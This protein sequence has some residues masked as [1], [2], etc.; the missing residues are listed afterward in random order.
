[1]STATIVLKDI[2]APA[3]VEMKIMKSCTVFK[4]NGKKAYLKG[5]NL[6]ITS[7]LK[8]LGKRVQHYT[9]EVIEKCHLGLVKA[10]I[11]DIADTVDLQKILNRYFK[12]AKPVEIKTDKPAAKTAKKVAVKKEK[13]VKTETPAPIISE[14]PASPAVA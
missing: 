3:N 10:A 9:A 13:A 4:A 14:L 7:P 12:A 8:E 6:E 1:M 2:K 11:P 5:S